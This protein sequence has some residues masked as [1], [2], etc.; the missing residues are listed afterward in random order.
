MLL[1]D[2][3]IVEISIIAARAAASAAASKLER[4]ARGSGEAE[5]ERGGRRAATHAK[6][7]RKNKRSQ[8]SE[9]NWPFERTDADGR[10]DAMRGR[11]E[12]GRGRGRTQK[13]KQS[14]S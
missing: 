11:T 9:Q 12:G 5:A 2:Q 10:E 1:L 14:G 4:R 13:Q 7:A 8:R 3:P 6:A